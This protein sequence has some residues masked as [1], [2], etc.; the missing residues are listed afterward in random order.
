MDFVKKNKFTIVFIVLFILLVFVGYKTFKILVPDERAAVYGDRLDG[1]ESHTITDEQLTS[2]TNNIKESTYVTNCTTDIKGKILYVN[3]EVVDDT[4]TT[5]VAG[6]PD[7]VLG[8]LQDDQKTYF[9][10]Q[11]IITKPYTILSEQIRVLED[12]I[13]SLTQQVKT[14]SDTEKETVNATLS[15][16][17]DELDAI[18]ATKSFPMIA[19][20][21][22]KRNAFVWNNSRGNGE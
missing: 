10:V 12:E 17:E 6:F 19:Y 4:K 8:F 14:A 22:A 9:D 11:V 3:I 21:N 20:K 5:A 1:I 7:A 13:A 16:K 2:I 15:S 18:I